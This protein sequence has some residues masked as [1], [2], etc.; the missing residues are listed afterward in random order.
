MILPVVYECDYFGRVLRTLRNVV[1]TTPDRRC[2]HCSRPL[3]LQ[4]KKYCAGC[5]PAIQREQARAWHKRT[6][7]PRPAGARA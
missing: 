4:R 7:V 5:A 3:P 6:Y 2:A 1:I